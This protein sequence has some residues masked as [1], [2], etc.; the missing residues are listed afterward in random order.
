MEE[1]S[2]AAKGLAFT[3]D[4]DKKPEERLNMVYEMVKVM[5][6]LLSTID[7]DD[8]HYF[9]KE[10]LNFPPKWPCKITMLLVLVAVLH[11]YVLWMCSFKEYFTLTWHLFSL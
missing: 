5:R 9:C 11:G 4:L 1:L 7:F 3:D 2:D 8:S 6:M 10:T